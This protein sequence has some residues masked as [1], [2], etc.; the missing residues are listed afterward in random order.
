[1]KNSH[2]VFLVL[3]IMV[4]LVAAKA[5]REKPPPPP[6]P[7]PEPE[8]IKPV[9]FPAKAKWFNSQPLRMA[10]LKGRKVVLIQFWRFE[11]PHCAQSAPQMVRLYH[12]FKNQG[13]VLI[14]VHTPGMGNEAEADA[15]QVEKKIREW[16]VDYPVVLDND[17]YLWKKYQARVYPTLYL[18]DKKGEVDRVVEDV[19]SGRGMAS[20]VD[21]VMKLCKD[22]KSPSPQAAQRVEEKTAPTQ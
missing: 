9:E 8:K 13:L 18:I 4:M 11:C 6:G 15:R 14:G 3:G 16:K 10:D 20:L 21:G 7:P 22:L 1:M 2:K 5:W 12:Q 19:E 17:A